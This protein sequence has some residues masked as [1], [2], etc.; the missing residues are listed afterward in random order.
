MLTFGSNNNAAKADDLVF[1]SSDAGFMADVIEAS[2]T[3]PILVDFWAP[4]CG[5]CKALGPALEKVVRAAQGK[6][7]LAKINIDEHPMVA[8]QLQVQS[9]PTVF[10]FH[11]GQPVDGFMGGLPESQLKEFVDRVI[12]ASGGASEEDNLSAALEI[13]EQSLEEGDLT[14]ASETFAAVL[15]E[16]GDNLRAVAG[17]ARCELAAGEIDRAEQIIALLPA[18]K[19]EDAAIAGVKS[20]IELARQSAGASSELDTHRAA[21]EADPANHQA[22]FDLALALMG[23]GDNEGAIDALLELFRRDREWNEGAART[24]LVKIFEALGDK[25]PL[26]LAGR[27]RLSSILFS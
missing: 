21:V 27:R 24:Q 15:S 6:V 5:P 11:N 14:T 20:A 18:D 25:D 9:I 19:A 4:W 10:A 12:A 17:L 3:R 7:A 26:T 23:T 16:Q 1:D 13:A 22:R 8:G 2:R